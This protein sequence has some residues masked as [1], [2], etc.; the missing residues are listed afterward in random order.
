MLFAEAVQQAMERAIIGFFVGLWI[1]VFVAF[2]L[3][4]LETF[5]RNS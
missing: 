2:A 4:A 3:P 5:T 1:F